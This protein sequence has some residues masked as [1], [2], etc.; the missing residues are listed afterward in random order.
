MIQSHVPQVRFTLKNGS[1]IKIE[2][3]NYSGVQENCQGLKA[4][5]DIEAALT[6]K[7]LLPEIEENQR[8]YKTSEGI[9]QTNEQYNQQQQYL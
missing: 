6:K 8:N 1:I 2:A 5:K 7:G 4:S 9:S 3:L